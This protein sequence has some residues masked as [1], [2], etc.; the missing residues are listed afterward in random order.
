MK[1]PMKTM[2]RATA[3]IAVGALMWGAIIGPIGASAAE[4][5][6]EGDPRSN[7]IERIAIPDLSG[8]EVDDEGDPRFGLATQ[9]RSDLDLN[10][11]EFDDEGDPKNGLLSR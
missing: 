2:V 7:P 5:D 8:V 10:G 11:V 9:Q 3:T 6:D 4:Y 1:N